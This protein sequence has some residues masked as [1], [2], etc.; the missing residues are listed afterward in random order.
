MGDFNIDYL[1]T[2]HHLYSR[3]KCL[4]ELLSLHQVVTEPTRSASNGSETLID[5]VFLSNI[6]QLASC[7]VFP[8]IANSDHSCIDV[9]LLPGK[10]SV[11]TRTKIRRV[12]WKYALADFSRANEMLESVNVD[13]LIKDDH[14]V[15]DTW[16]KWEEHFMSVMHQCI[17]TVAIS[18]TE[19][20]SSLA[21]T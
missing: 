9:V 4:W 3:L 16:R 17:P 18:A 10:S 5:Y 6:S 11:R 20:E 15:D 8:P 7:S 19:E 13:E 12:I 2:S 1:N 21:N 14:D